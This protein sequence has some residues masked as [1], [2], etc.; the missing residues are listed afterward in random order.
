MEQWAWHMGDKGLAKV[1]HTT[2]SDDPFYRNSVWSVCDV[3]W[4]GMCVL[5][6]KMRT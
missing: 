3:M 2:Q 1:E 6:D 4:P 5:C